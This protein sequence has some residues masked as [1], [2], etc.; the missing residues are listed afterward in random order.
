MRDEQSKSVAKNV[1]GHEQM[2]HEDINFKTFTSVSLKKI[3]SEY[4]IHFHVCTN[5]TTIK[6]PYI[7]MMGVTKNKMFVSIKGNNLHI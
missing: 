1:M 6:S 7:S 2:S 4:C 5:M 3:S